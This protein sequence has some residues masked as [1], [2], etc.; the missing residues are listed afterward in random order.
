MDK[1][2]CSRSPVMYRLPSAE[3]DPAAV[4]ESN[5]Q[6]SGGWRCRQNIVS[7]RSGAEPVTK[8]WFGRSDSACL[9]SGKLLPLERLSG[10]SR[11]ELARLYKPQ[12]QDNEVIVTLETRAVPVVVSGAVQK[13][14]KS[15]L[16]GR[17]P[18][19]KP[20]WKPEDSLRKQT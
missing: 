20:L 12:L 8:D 15:C 3:K 7:C 17:P 4:N 18:C 11:C 5:A 14:E 1:T 6:L 19:S 9:W 16:N 2:G 13:P 10:S